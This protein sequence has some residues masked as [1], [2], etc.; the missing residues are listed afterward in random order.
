MNPQ[1]GEVGQYGWLVTPDNLIPIAALVCAV[2]PNGTVD[3]VAWPGAMHG[4]WE[5]TPVAETLTAGAW[6][7]RPPPTPAV[8]S[9]GPP[10]ARLMEPAVAAPAAPGS[11]DLAS[12]VRA[13]DE[14]AP[15]SAPH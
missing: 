15:E 14:L 4:Y 13:V 11:V 8:P 6:S 5:A 12:L 3:V 2:R 1:V 9:L 10:S 7:P